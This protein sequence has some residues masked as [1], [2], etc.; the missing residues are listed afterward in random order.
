MLDPYTN[1]GSTRCTASNRGTDTVI[2]FQTLL[3]VDMMDPDTRVPIYSMS[4]P[5]VPDFW[6]VRRGTQYLRLIL[7][8]IHT[9]PS[10]EGD[11]GA[12]DYCLSSLSISNLDG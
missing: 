11:T 10:L 2:C 12:S 3:A 9:P 4:M 8:P 1:L 7:S 5:F 6:V